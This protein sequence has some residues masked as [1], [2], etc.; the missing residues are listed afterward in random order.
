M[1]PEEQYLAERQRQRDAAFMDEVLRLNE[2]LQQGATAYCQ[3]ARL[4]NGKKTFFKRIELE[5]DDQEPGMHRYW[6]INDEEDF[7]KPCS[8]YDNQWKRIIAEVG[9]KR[10]MF[11]ECNYRKDNEHN[12]LFT[13]LRQIL[14]QHAIFEARH[15]SHHGWQSRH[16]HQR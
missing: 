15:E 8:P 6:Y 7:C 13:G 4:Y 3:W 10:N 9:I 2:A 12:D 1:T 14:L 5:E 16:S 11:F